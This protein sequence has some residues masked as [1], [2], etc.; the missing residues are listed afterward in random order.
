M[1]GTA[2]STRWSAAEDTGPG[3]AL[4]PSLG[5]KSLPG[6]SL[7]EKRHPAAI[8]LEP[9]GE[10]TIFLPSRR[11]SASRSRAVTARET[12]RS[13]DAGDAPTCPARRCR[14]APCLPAP[15]PTALRQDAMNCTGSA[16]TAAAGAFALALDRMDGAL[17]RRAT[18]SDHP[19]SPLFNPSSRP[20]WRCR[21]PKAA[22]SSGVTV[23]VPPPCCLATKEPSAMKNCLSPWPRACS[24]IAS[25]TLSRL[26]ASGESGTATLPRGLART[27]GPADERFALRDFL[28]MDLPLPPLF[29]MPAGAAQE[30]DSPSAGAAL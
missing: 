17:P 1:P 7:S 30:T 16:G 4:D 28:A 19:P 14:K 6:T 25:A 23:E 9:S 29:H 2:A 5:A 12:E 3:L 21:S 27:D 13:R 10:R 24:T 22:T 18:E 11:T 8:L 20:S 15:S 26:K